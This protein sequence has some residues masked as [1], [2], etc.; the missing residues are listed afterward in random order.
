MIFE[1][2]KVYGSV[3]LYMPVHRHIHACTQ[4]YT[5]I[6]LYLSCVVTSIITFQ[7][8]VSHLCS[9]EINAAGKDLI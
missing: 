6:C 3:Y 7:G 9:R 8:A 5:G 1:V 4:A 2:V